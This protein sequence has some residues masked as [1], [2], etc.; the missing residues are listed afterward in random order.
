MQE[1]GVCLGV[2]GLQGG[3]EHNVRG[4]IG[5]PALPLGTWRTPTLLHRAGPE[6]DAQVPAE[7]APS[8]LAMALRAT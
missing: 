4:E 5:S 8:S 1:A 6:E 3:R 7:L 2:Q